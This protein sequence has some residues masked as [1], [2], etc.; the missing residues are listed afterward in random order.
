MRYAGA[1]GDMLQLSSVF[2]GLKQKYPGCHITLITAGP[3][4]SVVE[5]DPNID[6]IEVDT[7]FFEDTTVDSL[8]HKKLQ[9]DEFIVLQGS[10]EVS[11]LSPVDSFTHWWAPAVR[12]QNLNK[13]CLEFMHSIAQVPHVPQVRFYPTEE[14][15]EWAERAM[16]G[17]SSLP[18]AFV[19]KGSGNKYWHGFDPLIRLIL[20]EYSS[21]FTPVILGGED[22]KIFTTFT[23]DPYVLNTCGKWSFRESCTFLMYCPL[24]VGVDTGLMHVV[25]Q[26]ENVKIMLLGAST[27]ENVTRDWVNTYTITSPDTCCPGRGDNEAPA[28]HM[29]HENWTFCKQDPYLKDAQCMAD[30]PVESVWPYVKNTLDQLK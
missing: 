5:N 3:A 7:P 19:I 28:C 29:L 25:C 4:I 8:L 2:M 15:F 21:E 12:H 11:I 1:W 14:E 24:V 27:K 13:N 17:F 23:T 9:Y 30:I 10:V 26:T 6:K 16:N 22:A 18:I 20:H